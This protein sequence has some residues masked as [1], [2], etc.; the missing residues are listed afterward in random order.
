M[1]FVEIILMNLDTAAAEYPE[2]E[3]VW[4]VNVRNFI[5]RLQN[6]ILQYVKDIVQTFSDEEK[7]IYTIFKQQTNQECRTLLN[8][9]NTYKG[10]EIAERF[11]RIAW[12]IRQNAK[13][14]GVAVAKSAPPPAPVPQSKTAVKKA[15]SA[16]VAVDGA[17]TG[18]S[19]K[20]S[21]KE[22]KILESISVI[23]SMLN[24]LKNLV[25]Q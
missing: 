11:K 21:E 9:K 3:I 16:P 12:V 19:K 6:M 18:E 10:I 1:N 8:G 5:S 23:E 4:S 17:A 14:L 15:E 22:K 25:K 24:D 13:Q 20:L 2:Q 7:Q